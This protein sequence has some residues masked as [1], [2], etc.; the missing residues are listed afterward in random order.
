LGCVPASPVTVPGPLECIR[1][2]TPPV[3]PWFGSS[4]RASREF[5]RTS[6]PRHQEP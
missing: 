4:L 2:D 3:S 6:E 5:Q 1:S